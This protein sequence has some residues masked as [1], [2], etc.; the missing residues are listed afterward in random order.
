MAQNMQ[1]PSVASRSSS[2]DQ[3]RHVAGKIARFVLAVPSDPELKT[4]SMRR[5]NGSDI[6]SGID[7]PIPWM[8]PLAMAGLTEMAGS[9]AGGD[10]EWRKRR[11]KG[12]GKEK[13]TSPTTPPVTDSYD[14]AIPS[15][16][17][18]SRITT[19]TAVDSNGHL[20]GPTATTPPSRLLQSIQQA[21]PPI[22]TFPGPRDLT[23][24]SA[25]GVAT[26]EAS[27]QSLWPEGDSQGN[28]WVPKGSK[29]LR[30]RGGKGSEKKGKRERKNK[31]KTPWLEGWKAEAMYVNGSI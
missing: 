2:L 15:G 28:W 18:H 24:P 5:G 19:S 21:Y 8:D 13:A 12:K 31:K 7:L 9:E 27:Q 4:H 11:K 10:E 6:G 25:S 30:L 1:T 22:K 23:I 14:V 17:T 16:P 20:T 29:G 3:A 26:T